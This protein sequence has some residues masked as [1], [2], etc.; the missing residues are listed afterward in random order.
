M[1]IVDFDNTLFNTHT[2]PGNF[3]ETR[4]RDLESM[5]VSEEIYYETSKQ[6]RTRVT[7]G[8]GLYTSERHAEA[9][10]QYGFDKDTVLAALHKTMNKKLE[11]FLFPDA[12]SFLQ[13]LKKI[14][15]PMILF[16]FGDPEWQYE[17]V[18]GCD[19]EKYFDRTF[20]TDKPKEDV[21][22]ELLNHVRHSR[23]WFINDKVEETQKVVAS[24][25]E[26][27]GILKISVNNTLEDYK[28]S[29]L[30]FFKTLTEI[31]DHILH[32]E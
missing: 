25:P 3:V 10:A 16:S 29:G 30:P 13:D 24:F 19:I 12:S 32:Y 20:F 6:I 8:S 31:K 17:K 5:G 27:K 22:H 26:I 11:T 15:E 23:V 9:I 4:Y 28:Y 7:A 1:F 2:D 18:K 21:I 14:G